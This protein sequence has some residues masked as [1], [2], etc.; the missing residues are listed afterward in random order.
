MNLP[1]KNDSPKRDAAPARRKRNGPNKRVMQKLKTRHLLLEVAREIFADS[2]LALPTVEDV[3]KA[4]S[5]SRQGFYLHFDSRDAL[6]LELFDREVRWHMR[7]YRSL[8][9]PIATDEKALDE[10]VRKIMTAF[11]AQKKYIKINKRAL[12]ADPSLLKFIHGQRRR[13]ILHMGR[14]IPQFR[15]FQ[16]DGSVDELRVCEMQMMLTELENVSEYAAFDAWDETLDHAVSQI[17]KRFM[18]FARDQ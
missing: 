9:A 3:T 7:Y 2:T 4:A 8:G 16:E 10:W 6:L 14:K 1:L 18:A 12:T 11:A 15:I 13:F 5:I 17:V